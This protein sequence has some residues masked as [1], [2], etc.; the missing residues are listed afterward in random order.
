MSGRRRS[1]FENWLDAERA[2]AQ[3][4][5]AGAV[6]LGALAALLLVAQAWLLAWTLAGAVLQRTPLHQVLTQLWPLVPI[7]AG[8]FA[9]A[10]LTEQTGMR[11]AVAI[12]EGLRDR[13]VRHLHE[14]GPVFLHARHSGEVATA[15]V[16]GVEALE[17][18]YARYLPQ[19]ALALLVPVA[20]LAFVL[21]RDWISALVLVASA[22]PIVVFMI[23][24]GSGA[25]RRN[26]RQWRQL[27]RMSAHFLDALRGLV[28]LKMFNAARREADVIA[29]VSDEYRRSTMA[30]LRIAFLS[31]LVLEFFSAVGIALVAVL[32]G[33][34]LLRGDLGLEAGL[35]VLL[36]APEYFLPLRTLGTHYHARM[37]AIAAAERI[38]G[39]LEAPVPGSARA[40]TRPAL[41]RAFDLRFDDVHFAYEPGRD[42]LRGASF[43]L[44]PGRVA[45]LVGP[46][47]AGKSTVLNLLLGF[48]HAQRGRVLVGGH[49]LADIDPES[50]LA[51]VAWLPQRPHLFEGSILDNIRLG[52]PGASVEAV[53]AA[54]READADEFIG[55]LRQGYDTP[56]GERGQNLSGGQVQR[57]ALARAF[58]KDA[59]L[60]LMDEA[61]ASLD[62]ETEARVVAALARLARGRSLL[63]VAH[64]LRTVVA[65]DHVVVM[66]AGRVVEEGTH[67]A[68]ARAGG[69]YARL[70]RAH[71]AAPDPAPRPPPDP[72]PDSAPAAA[73]RPD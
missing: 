25:E 28:T 12:K 7:V 9:V 72:P 52:N 44:Q 40:V 70:V 4:A 34:R 48:V 61:T 57:I 58:L 26:Q 41:G 3:R 38:A 18:Y 8:R 53:R 50:W 49:D 45:A 65:A 68:L 27:A 23:L 22:P 32:I 20:I 39:I 36:L 71:D 69:L 24:I 46:S 62:A 5:I 30:V 14:L 31:S 63:V 6:G 17:S 66:D 51:H 13:L 1:K 11:G 47:G 2:L 55:R 19:K 54:A 29:R 67:E 73:L 33:F 60:V 43:A 21:P 59:P 10:A 56:V 42:A 35:F 64:R 15:V 37:E 16:D